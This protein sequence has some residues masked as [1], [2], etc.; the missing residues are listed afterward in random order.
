LREFRRHSVVG[1][2]ALPQ[3][4]QQVACNQPGEAGYK[5]RLC[6]TNRRKK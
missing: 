2:C 5:K 6:L 3:V 1:V 4:E